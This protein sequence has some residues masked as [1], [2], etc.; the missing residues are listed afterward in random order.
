MRPWSASV[1]QGWGSM[2]KP[3]LRHHVVCFDSRFNIILM[4]ADR[5]SHQ[6][7]LRPFRDLSTNFQQIGPLKSL[8][9][10][11][12]I[13]EISVIIYLTLQAS[14][15]LKMMQNSKLSALYVN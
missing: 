7:M 2:S 9:T 6:H 1:E 15:I 14:S 3:A 12:I 10:K 11:I 13:V 4:Y 8:K 5:N